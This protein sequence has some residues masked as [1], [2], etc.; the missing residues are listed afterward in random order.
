M[1]KSY[2]KRSKKNHTNQ[3]NGESNQ[4]EFKIFLV[5]LSKDQGIKQISKFFKMNYK[6]FIKVEMKKK[7]KRSGKITGYAFLSVASKRDFTEIVSKGSFELFGRCFFAK[8][9]LKGNKLANFKRGVNERRIFVFGLPSPLS[10]WEFEESLR[11]HFGNIECAFVVENNKT[12]SNAKGLGYATFVDPVEADEAIRTGEI[13]IMGKRAKIVPYSKKDCNGPARDRADRTRNICS[14]RR[15]NAPKAP[16]FNYNNRPAA[17]RDTSFNAKA[18]LTNNQGEGNFQAERYRHSYHSNEYQTYHETFFQGLI[19][20]NNFSHT[21]PIILPPSNPE[22]QNR[23]HFQGN[24]AGR[25]LHRRSYDP[26]GLN[27]DEFSKKESALLQ[28]HLSTFQAILN[29]RQAPDYKTGKNLRLN[30]PEKFNSTELRRWKFNCHEFLA[31]KSNQDF[32]MEYRVRPTGV[33]DPVRRTSDA[34]VLDM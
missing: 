33:Q 32:E 24:H 4:E 16:S 3:L 29:S 31:L 21:I 1:K 30:A 8:P 28:C 17:N 9:Y 22:R 7:N 5:G 2:T 27:K 34:N 18:Y 26:A 12:R 11:R 19:D 25:T 23:L 15:N 13:N 20:S 10:D 14:Y 6:S